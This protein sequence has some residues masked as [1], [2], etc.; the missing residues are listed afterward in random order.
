MK[1][2]FL[3]ILLPISI[4][5]AA[6]IQEVSD[7]FDKRDVSSEGFE[8][9]RIVVKLAD[10]IV[11]SEADSPEMAAR[12]LLFSCKAF[13]FLGDYLPAN[14]SEKKSEYQKGYLNCKKGIGLVELS[15]GKAKKEEWKDL[16]AD[17]YFMYT[18]NFGRWFE[19]EGRLDA[20]K[21]WSKEVRP[22]LELLAGDFKKEQIFG[23]GPIRALGRAWFSIPGGRNKAL[24]YLKDAYQKSIHPS[25]GVS[26]YPLNTAFYAEALIA[27][28]QEQEAQRILEAAIEVAGDPKNME[29]LKEQSFKVYGENRMPEMVEE[30]AL[31]REILNGMNLVESL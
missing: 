2:L 17:L 25:L 1:K 5:F 21:Y 3:L 27:K 14:R 4:S 15:F 31:C 13:Y 18:A 28:G 19:D 29:E 10:E 30:I 26:I 16:L 9:A 6:S 24:N 12:A 23:H 11:A 7:Y 8:N 22:V 20:L